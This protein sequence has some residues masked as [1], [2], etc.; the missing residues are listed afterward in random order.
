MTALSTAAI[1]VG[2]TLTRPPFAAGSVGNIMYRELQFSL[3]TR[4]LTSGDA[5]A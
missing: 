2:G 3:L 5:R 1:H 4:N